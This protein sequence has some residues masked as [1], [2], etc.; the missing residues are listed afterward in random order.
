MTGLF[1]TGTDTNIGKTT[2]SAALLHRYRKTADLCY[3]K[4]IQTG[5]PGDDDTATLQ[6]LGFCS[7]REICLEGIRLPRPLSPHLSAQYH[8]IEIDIGT[9]VHQVKANANERSWIVEGAGGL[10]VPLNA[11]QFMIDFISALGLPV[12]VVAGSQVGTINHTLLT[13]AALRSRL[14][15]VIGIVMTGEP[16][17]D[18]R[19]SIEVYGNVPV[20]GEMPRFPVLTAEIL[21]DWACT[22]LDPNDL[23]ES[24]L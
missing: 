10:L 5:F 7:D 15:P 4:P 11:G 14:I 22:H 2:V 8:G 18:N 9:L 6:S 12:L 13:L 3:W 1:I 20:L 21:A 16:N 24:L 17:A 19:R 23:L